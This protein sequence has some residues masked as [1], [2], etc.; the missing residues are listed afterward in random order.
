M[1]ILPAVK[2]L[3]LFAIANCSSGPPAFP[4]VPSRTLDLCVGLISDG[5][6]RRLDDEIVLGYIHFDRV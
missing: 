5:F 2:G 3:G 6:E 1:P 4:R